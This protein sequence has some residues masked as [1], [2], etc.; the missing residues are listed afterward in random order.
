MVV[1]DDLQKKLEEI[2]TNE[3]YRPYVEELKEVYDT[4]KGKGPSILDYQSFMCFYTTGSRREYEVK[5][6]ERRRRLGVATMLYLLYEEKEY[7]D[8]ICE[9]IWAICNELTWVLPAHVADVPVHNYRTHIALFAAETAHSLAETLY[10]LGDKLSDR[11]QALIRNEVKERTFDAFESRPYFWEKLISNWPGVC[12]SSI[13]MAYLY[14]APERFETV[15]DR[16]LGVLDNFLKSY[17][18]DGSNTEGISYWQYGFWMYLNFA[19]MLYRYS[20][21][22]I[23]IRH[24]EK[25]D[26]IA[27]FLQQIVLRKNYVV[28]FSDGARTYDFSH[29]GLMGYLLKNYEGIQI[30]AKAP[31]KIGI[32]DFSKPTWLIR[33]F[34]WSSPGCYMPESEL[35]EATDYMEDAKWYMV[36]K[37]KYSFAAKAGHNNEGHNHNDVGNF[38]LLDDNGQLIAD[39]GAMEY[40]RDCF[41]GHKRY[42]MLQNSSFGHS[43]PIIDGTAQMTGEK[44]CANVLSVTDTKFSMEIQDAYP[45]ECGKIVRTYEMRETGITMTD[46][47]EDIENHSITERFVS[48]IEP[49]VKDEVVCIGSATLY[50]GGIPKVSKE[51]IRDKKCLDETIWLIDYQVTDKTF[52][53][54]IEIEG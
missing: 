53:M 52:V 48:L 11:L 35:V 3:F 24:G 23:D 1:F 43:V 41:N 31:E 7:M 37:E 14:L 5:Y 15:K 54:K 16:I 25:V 42:L 18:D 2:R 33:D 38:I 30:Q 4:Y 22:E 13:G 10:L 51:V 34:L 45:L 39:M 28:S 9:M 19:D 27:R 32:A 20:E 17:G 26:K 8:E 44:Y 46:V 40:T 6:F 47:Y 49:E 21:G 29:I 12:A 36:K 50:A